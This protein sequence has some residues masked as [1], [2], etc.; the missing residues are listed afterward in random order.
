V[1]CGSRYY[2][3]LANTLNCIHKVSSRYLVQHPPTCSYCR[4]E[5]R[6]LRFTHLS[7]G[8]RNTVNVPMPIVFRLFVPIVKYDNNAIVLC[9]LEHC[10]SP[11]LSCS[12]LSSSPLPLSSLSPGRRRLCSELSSCTLYNQAFASILSVLFSLFHCIC[13]GRTFSTILKMP[14]VNG[15]YMASRPPTTSPTHAPPSLPGP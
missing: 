12:L 4:A 7:I 10:D 2:I 14:Y 3:K 5:I 8:R 11:C 9:L 13:A 6:Y 1:L 15:V